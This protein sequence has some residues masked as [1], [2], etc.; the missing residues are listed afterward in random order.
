VN[1][2]TTIE[3]GRSEPNGSTSAKKTPR[4][5]PIADLFVAQ[6]SKPDYLAP[7]NLRTLSPFHRALLVTDGTV[8]KFIEAYRMEPIDV[9]LLLSEVR[10]LSAH[11]HWLDA[12]KNADVVVREV[13]LQGRQSGDIYAYAVSLVVPQSLPERSRRALEVDGESLGRILLKERTETYR[14]IL[15]FGKETLTEL[16]DMLSHLRSREF[17]SRTYR[18]LAGG[19]PIMLIN[20]K[21]PMHG[22]DLPL[23]H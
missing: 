9:R 6:D 12:P 10:Q 17:L 4:P 22:D 15:W 18:I 13:A 8:T 2:Q 14:E 3:P 11:H 21:F 7:V 23:H 1:G 16:P 5:D 20:E 19:R